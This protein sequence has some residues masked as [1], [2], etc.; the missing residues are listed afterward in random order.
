MINFNLNLLVTTTTYGFQF[1]NTHL[2]NLT[3]TFII[4]TIFAFTF[5]II[6]DHIKYII[7]IIL[8]TTYNF[9]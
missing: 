7:I 3:R 6:A 1:A 5:S 2:A 4:F 9:D 8:N